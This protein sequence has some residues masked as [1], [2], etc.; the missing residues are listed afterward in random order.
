[1]VVGIVMLKVMKRFYSV[2][3]SP[4][5]L[6]AA[7]LLAYII[8]ENLK[9]NGVLAVATLGLL[10][11]NSYIREK[12]VLQSFNE[13]LNTTFAVIVFILIGVLVRLDFSWLF[14]FKAFIVF[15]VM[16]VSRYLAL[17]LSLRQ[18][19]FTLAEK[20]FMA[21]TMPTGIT[22]AVVA[23]SLSVF[24][25]TPELSP[26]MTVILQ[27]SL[28]SMVYS[29]IVGTVMARLAPYMLG[30]TVEERVGGKGQKDERRTKKPSNAKK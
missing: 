3:Y 9:G 8:A 23:F 12:E 24:G 16:V 4:A 25:A 7:T 1:V 22:V 2:E 27:L 19:E 21:F 10:F 11:G 18:G 28:I 30:E 14:L 13:I 26:Y 17:Q 6:I 5:G 20:V 29:L 15:L